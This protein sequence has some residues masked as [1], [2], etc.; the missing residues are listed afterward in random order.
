[1]PS[2]VTIPLYRGDDRE[3]MAELLKAAHIAERR[4]TL[5]KIEAEQDQATPAR[6]GDDELPSTKVAEAEVALQAARDAYDE[7][8]DKAAERAEEWELHTIGHEDFRALLADHPPR[9]ITEGEGDEAKQVTH[10]DDAD[11][12]FDTSKFGKALLLF[13]DPEDVENR[14]IHKPALDADALEK[15][16]KRLSAGEFEEFWVIAEQMN[17]G[18]IA[19]PKAVRFGFSTT[20]PM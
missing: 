13:R 2:Q 9:K 4:V 10:P 14:T 20:D 15:R 11:W 8:V 17:S 3:K 6:Y 19:D 7:Y 16:I 12:G 5:A 18:R 1:M